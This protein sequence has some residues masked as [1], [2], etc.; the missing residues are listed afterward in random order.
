MWYVTLLGFGFAIF[1]LALL[2]APLYLVVR[3]PENADHFVRI[4]ETL[5]PWVAIV[6]LLLVFNESIKQVFSGIAGA[7]SRIRRV[8]AAGTTTEF[9]EQQRDVYPLTREQVQQLAQYVESLTKAKEGETAWTWYFFIKYV[10]ATIYGSQ[11]KA[12]YALRDEGPKGPEE[13]LS[14][15][16]LFLEREPAGA[17]YKFASYV[18]YLVSNVLIQFD[19]TTQ[20]YH[21]TDNGQHLLRVLDQYGITWN[22]L[23]G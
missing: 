8:S 3:F 5:I 15:Y 1:A 9:E 4:A 20:K 12:L 16:Q 2:G 10:T 17:T 14:F 22:T 11:V 19:P 13:L 23:R 21:L 7:L 6:I 18:D